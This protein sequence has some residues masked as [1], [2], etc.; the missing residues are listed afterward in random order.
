VSGLAAQ[1]S[2]AAVTLGSDL[3]IEPGGNTQCSSVESTHGCLAIDDT[4]PGREL[5]APFDGVIVRWRVRL[6]AETVAQSIRIRVVR[7]VDAEHFTVISSGPPEEVPAGSG[8]YTF[9]STLPIRA[10]DQVGLEAGSGT[11]IEWRF[12][13]PGSLSHEFG[14]TKLEDGEI[15]EFPVFTNEGA[16]HSFNVDVEA[17]CDHDGLGD[18]SQ[19]LNLPPSCRP[20]PV[21]AAPSNAIALGK[22]KLNKKKGTAKEPVTVPGPGI[23]TLTGKG[24][25]TQT[26]TLT[27]AGTVKVLVKSKGKQKT[28]LNSTEKVKVKITVTYTPT[29]GTTNSQS[30]GLLLKKRLQ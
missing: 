2:S 10:G 28:K 19:D 9:P 29:G 13:T 8:T 16:A 25:V 3:A 6:G 11:Q 26:T 30:K 14:A 20:A 4:L 5:A 17:D 21:P 18:E 27:A 23:L 7:R 12:E 1:V 24:V 22:P 15:T